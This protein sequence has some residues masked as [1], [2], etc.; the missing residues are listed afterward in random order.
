MKKVENPERSRRGLLIVIEGGDGSGKTTQFNLL[1]DKLIKDGRQIETVDFP[2]Y[3]RPSALMIEKYLNGDFGTAKE[4]GAYRA[5]VL[6]ATDRYEASFRMKKWLAEGKIILANRYATSNMVHQSGKIKD[7]DERNKFLN[8]LDELE[9]GIFE[10]PR[11]DL[12]FFMNISA[13]I[14]QKLA[15]KK[16]ARHDNIKS[17]NDIH[18]NDLEHLKDALEAGNYV[19]KKY[20]WETIECD[21]GSGA[22]RSI[23][24]IHAEVCQRAEKHL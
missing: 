20:N 22:M 13:D 11:P 4:V 15:L 2:Q 14:S 3:G 17:K 9:F 1:K 19:A 5:S 24:D 12:V 18:E 23:E 7:S 6:Y 16:D 8:W 10:I 21:D